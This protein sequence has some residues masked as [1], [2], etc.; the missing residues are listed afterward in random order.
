VQR[1]GADRVIGLKITNSSSDDGTRF[2]LWSVKGKAL[3]VYFVGRSYLFD[4]LL[5]ELRDNKVRILD[6]ETS[7]YAYQQLTMLEMAYRQSGVIYS[8]PSGRH[9]D[10][11]IS[12]AIVVWAV[13]HPHLPVWCRV[14]EPRPVYKPRPAPSPLGWT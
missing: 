7:R 4:L 12:F 11:A 1:L 2:E 14:L 13:L 10:L 9:D 6:S 3:R 8:C 5:R